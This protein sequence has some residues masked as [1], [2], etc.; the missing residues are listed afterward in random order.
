MAE[1]GGWPE[2]VAKTLFEA[3]LIAQKEYKINT[4]ISEITIF[5]DSQRAIKRVK[6]DKPEPGQAL[7]IQTIAEAT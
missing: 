7:A 6:D 4:L 5:S 1:A 2:R 3:L